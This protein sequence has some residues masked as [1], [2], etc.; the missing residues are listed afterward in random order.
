MKVYLNGKGGWQL[1]YTLDGR[2]R[3]IYLGKNHTAASAA[4]VGEVVKELL[5]CRYR[6][7]SPPVKL[8]QQV[9]YFDARLTAT[10]RRHGILEYCDSGLT[11]GKLLDDFMEQKRELAESTLATYR[12]HL[13]VIRE[14]FGEKTLV[15]EIDVDRGL[16]FRLYLFDRDY[17]PV[18]VG[19]RVRTLRTIFR[20]AR[21]RRLV[22]ENPFQEVPTGPKT[23]DDNFRFVEQRDIETILTHTNRTELRFAVRLARYAGLRM[24]SEIRNMKFSDFGRLGF[25]VHDNPKT[26]RRE[27]P[28]FHELRPDFEILKHNRGKSDPVFSRPLTHQNNLR[29][30]FLR[31]IAKAGFEPWPRLFNNLRASRVTELDEQGFNE[32]TLDSIFGNTESIRRRHYV[33]FRKDHAFMRLLG[34]PYDPLGEMIASGGIVE[35]KLSGDIERKII[36]D[37][38]IIERKEE[39]LN[40]N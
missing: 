24:P 20:L 16:A 7:E 3:Q 29:T 30:C 23:N 22:Y 11:L 6:A 12:S 27:V 9:R 21:K 5:L 31:L 18:T 15:S 36:K 19:W 14:F 35:R 17:A 13:K 25:F 37:S 4:R 39:I 28:F 1:N 10:I 40:V 32:K 2:Q 34:E 8:L 26:G 33:G 38:G